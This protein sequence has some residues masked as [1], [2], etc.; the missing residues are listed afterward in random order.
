MRFPRQKTDSPLARSQIRHGPSLLDGLTS[1]RRW[2]V[3]L[4]LLATPTAVFAGDVPAAGRLPYITLIALGLAAIL[5]WLECSV[6]LRTS[7]SSNQR[8]S[9]PRRSWA[10]PIA[11][12]ALIS[13]IAVQSWFRWGTVIAGGDVTPPIGT[14]WI[15]RIF[16]AAL[17]LLPV[18]T[19]AVIAG[20]TRQVRLRTS[21]VLV[22]ATAPMLGYV[23]QN[24]PL[25]GMVIGTALFVPLLCASVS[26]WSAARRAVLI[27]ALALPITV[28]A[29][30][31]WVIPSILQLA[32]VAQG[33]LAA[34]SSWSWTEGRATVLNAFWLNAV[35]GWPYKE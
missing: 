28:A 12:A 23:Y 32:L 18:I 7:H 33:Q 3:V 17:A 34:I 2:L 6:S 9:E 29:S 4:A 24:P 22:I 20:A 11:A 31:Y 5:G 21:V 14:A 13:L 35:W 16:M 27:L 30:A 15:S 19:A 1:S 25:L 10:W 26:G 8:L